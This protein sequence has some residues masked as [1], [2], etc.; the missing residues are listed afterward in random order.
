MM[1]SGKHSAPHY[2]WGDNCD[3]WV[4]ADTAGLS[5]KQE[6]MPPGTKEQLHFHKQAQQYFFILKGLATFHTGDDTDT[7]GAGTGI[8]I[9]AGT[10]H[11]I[12]NDTRHELE[13]LV[14]SQPNTTNDRENCE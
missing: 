2:T 5:V 11:Y 7:I 8:L 12:A 4:L 9:E 14:I 3:S 10:K 13:F 6:S 1:V